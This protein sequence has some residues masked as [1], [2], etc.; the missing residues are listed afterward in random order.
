M[1]YRLNDDVISNNSYFFIQKVKFVG[2]IPTLKILV[3]HELSIRVSLAA[4]AMLSQCTSVGVSV[5]DIRAFKSTVF[6]FMGPAV[7]TSQ[8]YSTSHT[9]SRTHTLTHPN[10]Y[11][12]TH[13]HTPICTLSHTHALIQNEWH[14][15]YR[16]S[17]KSQPKKC[18][19]TGF[20]FSQPMRRK[21][22]A[23]LRSK[24]QVFR[25]EF[26]F[27][28]GSPGVTAN[29]LT[30]FATLPDHV[31]V[32]MCYGRAL[33]RP[34]APFKAGRISVKMEWSLILARLDANKGARAQNDFVPVQKNLGEKDN[35]KGS[36][37]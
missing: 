14:K 28:F 4:A 6:M 2:R 9:R 31:L 5:R 35:F 30:H 17:K 32:H 24:N 11:A 15:I 34:G 26:S 23:M 18:D 20:F 7:S 29:A 1:C 21:T 16:V 10:T 3:G 33:I 25:Q 36:R 12:S 8:H 37:K 27:S 13:T 22:K 19:P